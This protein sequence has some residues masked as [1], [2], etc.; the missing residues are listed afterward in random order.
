M[1]NNDEYS[2]VAMAHRTPPIVPVYDI[3]GNF[4]GSKIAATG[5]FQNPIATLVRGKDNHNKEFRILGNL[6]TSV[7]F[8]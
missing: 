5:N 2:P 7:K 4:A 1:T 6:Y 3:K 8:Y